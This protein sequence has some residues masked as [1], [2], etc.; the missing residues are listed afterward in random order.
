MKKPYCFAFKA[1]EKIGA[2]VIEGDDYGSPDGFRISAEM[3]D[4]VIWADYYEGVFWKDFEFGV[5]PKIVAI[6]R[7]YGLHAEWINPGVLGVYQ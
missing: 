3:N 2:P 1:L 6:L 5:N 7:K 4:K